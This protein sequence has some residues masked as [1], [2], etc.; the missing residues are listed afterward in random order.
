MKYYTLY[1]KKK[2]VFHHLNKYFIHRNIGLK[3]TD[4]RTIS[5][6]LNMLRIFDTNIFFLLFHIV[7]LKIK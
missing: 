5:N 3:T 2:N 4:T 6:Y 1:K 7:A